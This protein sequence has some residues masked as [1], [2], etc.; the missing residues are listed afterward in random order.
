MDPEKTILLLIPG[1][2]EA[3][4][5]L[6]DPQNSDYYVEIPDLSDVLDLQ[7][8]DYLVNN[9]PE[10]ALHLTLDRPS[11]S[12]PDRSKRSSR[13]RVGKYMQ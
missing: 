11:N 7:N 2:D 10:V 6:D 8:S 5:V 3:S 4:K 12:L 1:S 9:P 13:H